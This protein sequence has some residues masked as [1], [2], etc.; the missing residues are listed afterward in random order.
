MLFE[1]PY[2][3]YAEATSIKEGVAFLKKYGDKTAVMAGSTDLFALLKDRVEGPMMKLPQILLNI[4]TITEL[5][6]IADYGTSLGIGAVVTLTHI[7]QDER[8]R[9]RL[10][11]L[12]QAA[13]QVGTAQIRNMGTL[14]GNLCQRP[15]CMYFRHPDFPCFKKGGRKCFA[16][17][18]ENR[19]YHSVFNLG[20]CVMGHPSDMAPVLIALDAEVVIVD[21]EGERTL[22]LQEFF[23]EPDGYRETVIGSH[24]FLKEVRIPWPSGG[25][26][27]IF[28]K[29]RSRNA[30][31]FALVSVAAVAAIV[32]G[33][34]RDINVV[35]GGVAPVPYI[36]DKV[37]GALRNRHIQP[38]DISNIAEAVMRGA[39][40]LGKNRYKIDLSK[41]LV[42]RA[43]T[44]ISEV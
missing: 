22:P 42:R 13:S 10:P 1:L 4:K 21:Y 27:Q 5:N 41:A 29:E 14:G 39:K 40:F 2:F 25:N 28:L 31:D 32:D 30:A 11:V 44:M 3:E 23:A 16:A 12:S 19:D 7:S 17:T 35:L 9:Q 6:Q 18:G 20:K 8:I 34:C 43:L 15:R 24:Q 33:I 38:N 36:A 26:R 37:K